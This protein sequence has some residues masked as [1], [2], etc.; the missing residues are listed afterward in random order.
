MNSIRDNLSRGMAV[1]IAG[2][3][4]GL[5]ALILGGCGDSTPVGT[6]PQ[7]SVVKNAMQSKDPPPVPTV[8][9]KSKRR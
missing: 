7:N 3:C 9:G 1:L 8:R 6:D 2:S 4:L 5:V